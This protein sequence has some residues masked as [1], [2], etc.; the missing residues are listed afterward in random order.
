MKTQSYPSMMDFS[1]SHTNVSLLANILAIFVGSL[2]LVAC[3]NIYI[4]LPFTPVPI[5]AQTLGV[6]TLASMTGAGRSTLSVLLYVMYGL[7]GFPVFAQNSAGFEILMGATGGYIFGF[8][9]AAYVVGKFCEKG[10]DRTF[11]KSLVA[12][13]LGQLLIFVPGL[14]WLGQFTGYAQV[15][16]KGFYPFVIGGIVKT[17]LGASTSVL[18]WKLVHSLKNK[19]QGAR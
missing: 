13:L 18:G 12:M 11:P 6:L 7:V 14:L 19:F 15:L 17:L 16:E 10:W 4:P 2:V 3:A 5:T 8:F 1:F 9:I